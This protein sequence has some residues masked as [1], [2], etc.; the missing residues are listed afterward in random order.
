M[1]AERIFLAMPSDKSGSCAI[2]CL[3]VDGECY[4]GN[5][6]DSRAIMSAG[7]GERIMYLSRDHRPDDD[8]ERKRIEENGGKV[9]KQSEGPPRVSPGGLSVSRT[10][11]DI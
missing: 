9:Y 8:N 7:S 4:V 3:I 1:D 6:G 2:V 10:F 11:G 5:V